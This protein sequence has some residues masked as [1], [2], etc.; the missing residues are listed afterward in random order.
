MRLPARELSK[1]LA[2]ERHLAERREETEVKRAGRKRNHTNDG[3]ERP[4]PAEYD[5]CSNDAARV[6]PNIH[7]GV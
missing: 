2:A 3:E 1:R 6:C 5:A 4:A 7:P